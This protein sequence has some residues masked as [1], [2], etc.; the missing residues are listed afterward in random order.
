MTL[1]FSTFNIKTPQCVYPPLFH[2]T[3]QFA[4]LLPVGATGVGGEADPLGTKGG[5]ELRGQATARPRA[6]SLNGL[7]V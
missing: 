4:G 3:T 7:S 2:T 6:S 5:V 1:V